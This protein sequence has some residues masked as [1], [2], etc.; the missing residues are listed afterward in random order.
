MA[1]FYFLSVLLNI[2]AGLVLVYGKSLVQKKNEISVSGD[3]LFDTAESDG[4][5]NAT[6]KDSVA[7]DAIH[8]TFENRTFRL[9]VG[10]L[11][12][13]VGIMKILSVFRN[14]IPVIGDLVPALAGLAGGAALLVEYYISS[15]AADSTI[16]DNIQTV[17]IDSR[18]YIGVFCLLA[19]LL[20]FV[21]PQVMLL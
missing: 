16:P 21:F 8:G 1:Q 9:V 4:A 18:K 15:S 3:D 7:Y 14:D 5:E 12:V 10:I 2:L 6:T 13:F 17:F 20:H 19:G 11:A